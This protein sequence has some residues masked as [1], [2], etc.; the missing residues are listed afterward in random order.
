MSHGD[1]KDMFRGVQNN[2]TELVGYYIRKGIDINYQH[3]EFMTNPLFESI[4]CGHVEM[5]ALLL[6]NGASPEVKEMHSDKIPLSVAKEIGKQEILDL[7]EPNRSLAMFWKVR[8]QQ[9]QVLSGK[10][11]TRVKIRKIY[12]RL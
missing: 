10:S 8:Q 11:N 3:P 2:D 4:R 5:T 7:I 6:E 1:W 12:S 9:V